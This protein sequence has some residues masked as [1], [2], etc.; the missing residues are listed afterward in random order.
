MDILNLNHHKE[1]IPQAAR[2][3]HS[4]WG[5]PEDAYLQSMERAR[6]AQG[7]VPAWY[8]VLEE[9]KIAAGLGIIENDFHKRPDLTPNVCAVF[10]EEPYR[11]K[12]LARTLL[13]HACRELAAHGVKNAYLITTHTEFYEHC[14][15]DFY[16]MIQ[17]ASGEMVRMYQHR[18]L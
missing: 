15:W 8:V 12:G 4:K 13:T 17:E 10:V 18:C 1:L 6:T 9:G 7:G 3:F 16:G 14:G 11:G 5:V 2:W